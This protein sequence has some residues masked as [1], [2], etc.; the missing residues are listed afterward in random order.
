LGS[1]VTFEASGGLRLG[2]AT[3]VAGTGVDYVAV[4]AITH[5][6]QILDIALDLTTQFGETV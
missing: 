2:D 6:T 5:S 4:G 3:L 1:R